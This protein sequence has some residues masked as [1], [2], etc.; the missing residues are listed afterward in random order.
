MRI[1]RKLTVVVFVIVAAIFSYNLFNNYRNQDQTVPEFS[2]ADE[3][4][5]LQVSVNATEEELK[6]GVTAYDKKD[7]DLTNQITI[8]SI[9]KFIS[10]HVCK[11]T[12]TVSDADNHVSRTSRKIEFTDYIS[13]RFTLSRQLC[14]YVGEDVDVTKIIGAK[15]VYENK[16]NDGDISGKVKL[17]SS[18]VS[19]ETAGE[20]TITA[21]V[22]NSLGDT[23]KLQAMVIVRQ[24]DNLEP[25]IEL[26]NN[27]VYVKKDDDFNAFDYIKSV[28]TASGDS[29]DKE[30]VKVDKISVDTKEPGCYSVTY[31]VTDESDKE[32]YAF[33]TVVVTD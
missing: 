28:H 14:L 5:V 10:G 18:S 21:Q 25:V 7:G 29:M 1:I 11:I 32:G 2:I 30:K 17:L 24:K 4:S 9:S 12:Y 8:E 16:E 23:S 19:T 26:E 33:L 27:I 31:S 15:D 20:Y 3:D 6:T 22:T 13:P